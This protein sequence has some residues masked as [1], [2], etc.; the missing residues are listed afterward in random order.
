MRMANTHSRQTTNGRYI[1]NVERLWP[2]AQHLPIKSILL[3]SI[4]E[5]DQDCWFGNNTPPTCRAVA[6][7]AKRIQEADLSYPILLSAEGYLI[8]GGHRIAKAWLLGMKE[9]QAVQFDTDPD[10]DEIRLE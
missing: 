2:L 4:P 7:H 3:E 5:F 9:I 8:D 6:A 1:W 10:P